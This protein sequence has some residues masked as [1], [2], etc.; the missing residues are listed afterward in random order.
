M[1]D[2]YAVLGW[3]NYQTGDSVQAEQYFNAAYLAEYGDSR[4]ELPYSQIGL[5]WAE[6]LARTS[7]V[8]TA[9]K[10]TI[11]NLDSSR[12]QRRNDD[13]ARCRALLARL[14]PDRQ[15]NSGE[16]KA[17]L[18]SAIDC[19]RD[20]DY[21]YELADAMVVSADHSRRVGAMDTAEEALLEA[22]AIAGP[23][24][25]LPVRISILN[26]RAILSAS[27]F[28]AGGQEYLQRGRDVA[29]TALRLSTSHALT[30]LQL[31]AVRAHRHLD[32][33]EGIDNGWK[34][35]E[36][37]LEAR[38]IPSNLDQD[39]IATLQVRIARRTGY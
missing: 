27:R 29:D 13:S 4:D 14:S 6:F 18:R 3:L 28:A 23:R 36:R 12:R 5:W 16:I 19:F 7:R 17:R 10:L 37:G 8:N 25:L 33:V 22:E 39:P 20:G 35:R 15:I 1:A 21:M 2:A 31:D 26:Q 34:D 30:W 24:D 9:T 11:Y 32:D 38:L